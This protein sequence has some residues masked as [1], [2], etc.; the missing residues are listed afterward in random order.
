MSDILSRSSLKIVI[1]GELVFVIFFLEVISGLWSPWSPV[2]RIIVYMAELVVVYFN[3]PF[4]AG[5]NGL[6]RFANVCVYSSMCN[7]I[8]LFRCCFKSFV[9]FYEY[10]CIVDLC[11][12]PVVQSRCTSS[13]LLM[14]GYFGTF[15]RIWFTSFVM[16]CECICMF[17]II[18]GCI[19]VYVYIFPVIIYKCTI[20]C[21]LVRGY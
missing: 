10:G 15:P 21:P 11:I 8:S 14:R 3:P 6:K 17:P 13:C 16:L 12:S 4:C 20:Y 19:V 5:C 7:C 18:R 9:P 1:L 2:R